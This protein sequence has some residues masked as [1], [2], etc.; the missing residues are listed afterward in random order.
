[1]RA[2][3]RVRP[4]G[5]PRSAAAIAIA[6]LV[7]GFALHGADAAERP[8]KGPAHLALRSLLRLHDLPPGY[9]V[10]HPFAE[11]GPTP[12]VRCEPL[13]PS[14]PQPRVKAFVK[15]YAP[16]GCISYYARGFTVPGGIPAPLFVAT[17]ALDPRSAESARTALDLAPEIF[18]HLT[19][20]KQPEELVPAQAVGEET[21]LFH[22]PTILGPLPAT[23]SGSILAWR[24]GAVA[25]AVFATGRSQAQA[26]ATVLTLAQRQ[27]AHIENPTPYTP[28]ERYDTDILLDSPKLTSPVLWLGRTFNPGGG[29]GKASLRQ[30]LISPW[31]PRKESTFLLYG[32]HIILNSWTART[33]TTDGVGP[34]GAGWKCTVSRRIELPD[35][36]AELY[37]AHEQ[38]FH[39][40]PHERPNHFSALLRSHGLVTVIDVHVPGRR[41]GAS[42]EYDS[43]E[44]L[45]TIARGLRVRPRPVY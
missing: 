30:A 14:E 8:A 20:D 4:L 1:M 34:W 5:R 19:V 41:A 45:A 2:I 23:R 24:S 10:A 22:W 13:N 28:A 16:I 6:V 17:A 36:F 43:F 39:S 11:G 26:D 15:R 37:A 42:D 18:S 25:A 33:W 3:D 12:D 32:R 31:A 35:G 21:R 7:L 40:C 38:N 44:G 27:Q 9:G 29:L